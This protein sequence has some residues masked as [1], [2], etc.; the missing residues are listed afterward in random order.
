MIEGELPIEKL[1]LTVGGE[2][3]SF[4]WKVTARPNAAASKSI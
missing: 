3:R 2:T 4:D 1:T